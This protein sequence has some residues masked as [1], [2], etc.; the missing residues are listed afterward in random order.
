V[1]GWAIQHLKFDPRLDP[2]YSYTLDTSGMAWEVHA[3]ARKAGLMGFY[4][5]S[6]NGFGVDAHYNP[7]GSATAID[8][9]LTGRSV[10]GD[11]FA[12]R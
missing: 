11:S 12:T 4:F 9:Y 3:T 1:D 8:K 7:S 10:S 2:N 6:R 5:L